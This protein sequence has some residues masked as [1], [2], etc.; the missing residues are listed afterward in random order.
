MYKDAGQA[1]PRIVKRLKTRPDLWHSISV[2]FQ[3]S[4]SNAILNYDPKAWKLLWGP[5]TVREKVGAANF[6]FRPQVFRQ[7]NLDLFEKQ[8]IPQVSS[9]VPSGA[10]V[11]ELYSGLGI[12]G[13]NCASRASEVLCS[14]SNEYVDEVFD[15]CADSLPEVDQEKVFF[16]NMPAE[17]AIEEGQCERSQVLIVDPPRRGLDKGVL[18]MLTGSH[19]SNMGE[20]LSRLIYISC[21][22]DA[23]ENDAKELVRAGWSITSADG[24]MMFPGSNH[25]ETV[26]VF[27]RKAIRAGNKL[28]AEVEARS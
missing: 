13:L 7:A 25:I 28:K 22:F 12:V 3:T 4:T 19:T 27:D 15:K 11:A 17:E 6:Y 16:E 23:L 24:Y 9:M 8:I 26:A 14:D 21:G 10:K 2:N 5:P 1:L 20:E 18:D